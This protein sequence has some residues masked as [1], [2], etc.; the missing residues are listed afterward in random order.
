MKI[1]KI[2]VGKKYV[3]G[4]IATLGKRNLILIKGKN[5]YVMCG[6][7]NLKVAS[8]FGDVAVKITGISNFKQALET[9]VH[10]C[11]ARAKNKGIHKGQ[12]IREVLKIIA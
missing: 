5:G 2:K 9:K 3:T 6:Y 7:L 4:L 11:S 10:S 12:P 8:S 1:K